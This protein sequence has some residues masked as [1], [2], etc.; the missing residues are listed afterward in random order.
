MG[1]KTNPTGFRLALDKNWQSTWHDDKRYAQL[2][3]KDT[4]IREFLRGRLR[5]AGVDEID[6]Q[7]SIGEIEINISVARPG[8]VIGRGGQNIEELKKELNSMIDE[9]FHLN[10]TE[11]S[12]PDLSATLIADA[13]VG[14]IM[15][16][17]PYKRAAKSNLRKVMEAGAKGIKIEVAG[18]LGGG[19]I[20][21][22]E[23]FAQGSVPTSTIRQKID[24]AFDEAVTGKGTIGIK[25]WINGKED[26]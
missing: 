1:Q 17:Y 12:N 4:K 5:S 11:V 26:H 15:R 20:A 8:L 25:V 24:Y 19:T 2:L 6:I 3:E 23:K 9:K 7:R 21:R 13:M 14:S 18:R 22:T 10:V 16:R